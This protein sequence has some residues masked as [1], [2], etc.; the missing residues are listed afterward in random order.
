MDKGILASLLL[1]YCSSGV[2]S[3]A[4]AIITIQ[5]YHEAPSFDSD[6][7]MLSPCSMRCKAFTQASS[8]RNLRFA[9][10]CRNR[11][12]LHTKAALEPFYSPGGGDPSTTLGPIKVAEIPGAAR[13][14]PAQ[15]T[16]RNCAC[17]INSTI[18]LRSPQLYTIQLHQFWPAWHC[19][20]RSQMYPLPTPPTPSHPAG[21]GRGVVATQPLAKGDL[22]MVSEPLAVIWGE[23]W[24][25]EQPDSEQLHA[26]M[27]EL[28]QYSA[29]DLQ[30]M[31]AMFN[32][33]AESLEAPQEEVLQDASSGAAAA[34]AAAAG[35]CL[36]GHAGW[37]R[38]RRLQDRCDACCACTAAVQ[39][40][41]EL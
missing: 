23:P 21:K 25:A 39:E 35:A 31:A 18:P 9:G 24:S 13:W 7:T 34:A 29:R 20:H 41:C 30:L 17:A 22:V 6:F 3:Y 11:S 14:W 40:L 19:H 4:A 1:L 8:K 5:H 36:P 32:G 38:R 26:Y 33:T 16:S 27:T 12:K 2:P 15:P 10:H 28:K 37:R